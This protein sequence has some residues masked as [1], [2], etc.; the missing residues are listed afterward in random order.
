MRAI[1]DRVRWPERAALGL[2]TACVVWPWVAAALSGRTP[3]LT[4][5]YVTAPLVLAVGV[6]LGRLVATRVSPRTTVAGLVVVTVVLFLSVIWT[7]GPAKRPTA[8]ANANAAVAVQVIGLTGLAMLGA[9]RTRKVVLWL[10]AAGAVAVI[11]ANSSKAAG[12]V[13]VPLLAAIALMA[14]RPARRPGWAVVLGATSIAAAAAGV[15][16]LAGRAHWPAV[17]VG[18]LDPARQEL[19]QDALG[20]WRE[21]P[22]TG[23]GPGSLAAYGRLSRDPDT[24]AA[25]SS[26]LQ[27][28]AETGWVGVVLFALLVVGGLWWV[29][30][31]RAPN[32]V[33]AAAAWTAL[34]IHS[35]VD[36][37]LEY[38]PVVAAAGMV[39]GW[40]GAR[41]SEELDVPEGEPPVPR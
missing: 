18:A 20:L 32:A 36:H 39:L 41:G 22:V 24:V 31:G 10:T 30:R 17:V 6:V 2:L 5:P 16:L 29:T 34:G 3:S 12:A 37:L 1:L 11:Y 25:H 9:G 21:H 35:L 40:A 19:W 15:V 14:W 27:F 13:A 33:V 23:G 28:G 7:D 38:A 26:I 4:S 8:Y